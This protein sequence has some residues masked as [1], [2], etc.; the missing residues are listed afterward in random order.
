ML[1]KARED[2]EGVWC[3]VLEWGNTRENWGALTEI[4]HSADVFNGVL[5]ELVD[6]VPLFSS[7]SLDRDELVGV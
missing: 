6:R 5:I 4:F 1:G 2:M 7:R 3:L